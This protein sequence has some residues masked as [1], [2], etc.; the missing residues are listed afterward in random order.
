MQSCSG[1]EPAALMN[2][3]ISENMWEGAITRFDIAALNRTNSVSS[4]GERS[5]LWTPIISNSLE[6]TTMQLQKTLTFKVKSYYQNVVSRSNRHPN[7][8][9]WISAT[10]EIN[11]T[12]FIYTCSPHSASGKWR[13]QEMIKRKTFTDGLFSYTSLTRAIVAGNE[14][15]PLMTRPW[16]AVSKI[17]I[18]WARQI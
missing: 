8:L 18:I 17:N 4:W 6:R 2:Q 9:W 3:N 14:A 12:N 7:A 5:I 10:M 15:Y 1:R 11:I 16:R 13:I